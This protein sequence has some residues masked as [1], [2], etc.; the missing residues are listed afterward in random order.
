MPVFIVF[1]ILTAFGLIVYGLQIWSVRSHTARRE[2]LSGFTPPIS[3]LKPLKGLDDKLFD[4]IESF[5]G[6]DY[7]E[8]ELI[9]VLQDRNDPAYKVARKIKEKHPDRNISIV[10]ESCNAGLNPKVNNLI[11]ALR[12]ARYEYVLISDSN[13][14]ADRGY[15]RETV[16][17]MEDPSVG[18]V[19]NPI[20]GIGGRSIGALL[21]NI[22]LNSFVIGSVCFLDRFL[23]MPCVV[24]KSMLMRRADLDAI[25][26]FEAFKDVLAEDYLIGRKM[27]EA[28]KR[29]VVSSHMVNNVNDYWGIGKFLNRHT[30][31]GKLRWR[32]GGAGYVSELA[33]NAVL[34]ACL[35]LLLSGFSKA[36]VSLALAA[37]ISKTTGDYL[38]GRKI[39]AG[40]SPMA[41]ALVPAKDLLMGLIW[42]VPLLSSTV[43]WMSNR[44]VIGKDSLLSPYH[45]ADKWSLSYRLVYALKAR[46][47]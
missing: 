33:S 4:N 26:G 25:G 31:W 45:D 17:H 16:R 2:K 9:L 40:I 39:G 42:F 21:E 12:A 37:C 11:P 8:Y 24:G 15:L 22:H 27:R 35:P 19:T 28:G 18:L 41:Y 36:T 32:I 46:L 7:P 23:D 20:R 44:Y 30:R 47:T 43:V 29:V 1:A 38:L 3:I 6:L 14:M 34:M 13:V 5:C 10:V